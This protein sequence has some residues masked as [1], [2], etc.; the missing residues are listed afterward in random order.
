MPNTKILTS[1]KGISFKW[2][3]VWVANFKKQCS[4][5]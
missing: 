3:K 4:S 1:K 5:F 2:T